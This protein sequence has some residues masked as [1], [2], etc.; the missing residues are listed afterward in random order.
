M[1][2]AQHKHIYMPWTQ[3]IVNVLLL[4]T[5]KYSPFTTGIAAVRFGVTV[6]EQVIVEAVLGDEALAAHVAYKVTLTRV[7]LQVGLQGVFGREPKHPYVIITLQRYK[8]VIQ[9]QIRVQ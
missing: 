1:D 9:T 3:Y 8:T 6:S 5:V 7:Q 2:A 4:E